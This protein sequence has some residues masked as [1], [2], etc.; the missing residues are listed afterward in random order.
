MS[1]KDYYQL[2]GVASDALATQIKRAFRQLSLKYHPDKTD[3]K[4]HHD[5][6]LKVSEAYEV[7]SSPES[8]RQYDVTIGAGSNININIHG[9]SPSK[10]SA[11]HGNSYY[12]FYQ[13]Y[14]K[15]PDE[16][17]KQAEAEKKRFEQEKRQA[18]EKARAED[19]QRR[20][21]EIREAQQRQAKQQQEA[22]QR[23]KYQQDKLR[24]EER[25][26]E[27]EKI[28]EQR[29]RNDEVRKQERERIRQ[30]LQAQEKVR[31]D[32][33][34]SNEAY[35]DYKQQKQRKYGGKV[36]FEA[37]DD[38]YRQ[39]QQA[40]A[41]AN[42]EPNVA[43]ED[44]LDQQYRE[45]ELE[46]YE[47]DEQGHDSSDPIVVDDNRYAEGTEE[48][49]PAE[50]D[51]TDNNEEN[52]NTF[53]STKADTSAEAEGVDSQKIPNPT[54][55]PPPNEPEINEEP[56]KVDYNIL[57]DTPNI[58][59]KQMPNY[60]RNR[61]LTSPSRTK[62]KQTNNRVHTKDNGKRAKMDT[63]SVSNLQK[64]LG[65]NLED[66]DFN[67]MFE[68]LTGEK[69]PRKASANLSSEPKRPRVA[70]YSDGTL[71]VETL[72]TPINRNSIKGHAPRLTKADLYA[73]IAFYKPPVPPEPVI[74]GFVDENDW[75]RYVIN[76]E[77]Y[78][79]DFL[80]YK[81]YMVQYL[82]KRA[83]ADEEYFTRINGNS[84]DFKVYQEC[85]EQDLRL[86]ESFTEQLRKFTYI[87]QV[88]QQNRNWMEKTAKNGLGI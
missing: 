64:S 80:Q 25:K 35:E 54:Q 3:D 69:K 85:V 21:Q 60:M 34:R 79:K 37:A 71:K 23:Q 10:P 16:S 28:R 11:G 30:H 52:D 15:R 55:T 50:Q 59:P 66:S 68:S 31:R 26:R 41:N 22:A 76:I 5:L 81:K 63:F 62:M 72:H 20:K 46:E 19:A 53:Y 88:Y 4:L 43:M 38:Y 45:N 56:S 14:Y 78:G 75:Q 2:L 67:D 61:R 36:N 33:N 29:R 51:D 13:T 12:G 58:R 87:M 70:E 32:I 49:G 47:T 42:S 9:Y 39:K 17:F 65:T 1:S 27:E 44:K 48:D 86:Q 40:Y 7:L 6:F 84:E 8:K 73:N 24:A 74:E 82:L 83:E 18:F 77:N 57:D